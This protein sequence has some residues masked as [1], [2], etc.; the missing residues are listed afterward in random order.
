MVGTHGGH[1]NLPN[2]WTIERVRDVSRDRKANFLNEWPPI[3]LE[4]HPP[5]GG[6]TLKQV[7][8]HAVLL[9]SGFY[10]AQED[11][12]EDDWMVGTLSNGRVLCWGYA[13]TLAEALAGL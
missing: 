8:P 7:T 10:L 11:Q 2:G 5:Q 6:T 1:A 3:D 12:S 4:L 13:G 9:V